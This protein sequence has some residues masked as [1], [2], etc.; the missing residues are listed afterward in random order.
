MPKT[1]RLFIAV[2]ISDGARQAAAAHIKELRQEF[3]RIRV[4]WA[5]PENLHITLKFLGD[6]PDAVVER[7]GSAVA[8]A[9]ARH[10]PFE[11][12]LSVPAAFGKRVL[13]IGIADE[14]GGVT[15]LQREIE[16]EYLKL[17]FEKERRPFRPHLTIARLRDRRGTGELIERH[18]ELKVDPEETKIGDIVLYESELY[19][20]GSRYTVLGRY[21]LSGEPDT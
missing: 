21:S 11:I 14:T 15:A 12:K 8:K 1:K 2:N 18:L 4:S 10:S 13:T 5:R 3:P 7:L 17:G 9:A 6:T 20:A 16:S 19:P